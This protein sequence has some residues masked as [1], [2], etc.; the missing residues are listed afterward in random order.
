M[1]T[2][3]ETKISGRLHGSRSTVSGEQ[4]PGPGMTEEN[5]SKFTWSRAWLD[6]AIVSIS[7]AGILNILV[8]LEF[9]C[10]I[11]LETVSYKRYKQYTSPT[12]TRYHALH[13]L[14]YN[15]HKLLRSF[16]IRYNYI[17]NKLQNMTDLSTHTH[18]YTYLSTSTRSAE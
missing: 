18:T 15:F 10:C 6:K 2:S 7:G 12:V 4:I 11:I 17:V 14:Q 9:F 8:Y 3:L 1:P 13:K 5:I 16:I